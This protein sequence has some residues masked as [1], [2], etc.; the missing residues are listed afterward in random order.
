VV[1]DVVVAYCSG[2]GCGD[3]LS[4]ILIG[5]RDV[6]GASCPPE[7][8]CGEHAGGGWVAGEEGFGWGDLQLDWGVDHEA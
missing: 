2:Y 1:V 3:A 8:P 6:V 4:P 5:G 7:V